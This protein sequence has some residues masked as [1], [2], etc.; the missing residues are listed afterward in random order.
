MK[1][2]YR[3]LIIQVENRF[4]YYICSVAVWNYWLNRHYPQAC[5]ILII[6]KRISFDLIGEYNIKVATV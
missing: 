2:K 3:E 6:K 4:Y 1:V 5:L